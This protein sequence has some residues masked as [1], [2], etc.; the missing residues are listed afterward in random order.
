[1]ILCALPRTTGL[2]WGSC[3]IIYFRRLWTQN[4]YVI[5]MLPLTTPKT[6][7]SEKGS[8]SER[9]ICM[10]ESSSWPRLWPHPSWLELPFPCRVESKVWPTGFTPS[11]PSHL[12]ELIPWLRP[13]CSVLLGLTGRPAVSP[14]SET[15]QFGFSGQ[16][17]S[18]LA[19]CRHTVSA[20]MPSPGTPPWPPIPKSIFCPFPPLCLLFLSSTYQWHRVIQ[21][22]AFV[23]SVSPSPGV[24][25]KQ[26]KLVFLTVYSQS[27]EYHLE[28]QRWCIIVYWLNQ[29]VNTWT[30]PAAS[31]TC[32]VC[33]TAPCGFRGMT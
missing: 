18:R 1:M 2:G 21:L 20:P 14:S 31:V 15:W 11:G 28:G 19:P 3:M 23:L 25:S 30:A 12:S 33:Q 4:G 8:K 29:Y 6:R 26:Q 10:L 22:L 32:P 5:K 13:S 24:S 16:F 7:F 17:S 27:P 9:Q